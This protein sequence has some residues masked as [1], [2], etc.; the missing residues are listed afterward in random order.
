MGDEDEV[1][2]RISFDVD[3]TL[4]KWA[5]AKRAPYLQRWKLKPK[6]KVI[7][8]FKELSKNEENAVGII[9]QR[10]NESIKDVVEE[11]NLSPDF[12]CGARMKPTPTGGKFK[13]LDKAK[14]KY[15]TNKC[16]HI[17]DSEV[18]KYAAE[19]AGCDYLTPKEA[20]S[21]TKEEIENGNCKG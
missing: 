21:C 16:I 14:K 13:C 2:R 5:Y 6:K 18:D 17:G 19:M 15:P 7:K 12:I 4:I 3:G 20:G 8:R 9:S 1:E 10:T 11:Y